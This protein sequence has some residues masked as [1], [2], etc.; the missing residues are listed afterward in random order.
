MLVLWPVLVLAVR[1]AIPCLPAQ[2]TVLGLPWRLWC[3]EAYQAK[4][5]RH[6]Q[7]VNALGSKWLQSLPFLSLTLFQ[8][9]FLS[10]TIVLIVS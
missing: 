9:A 10:M 5:R 4:R 2:T 1:G 6:D 8:S 7:L 3:I